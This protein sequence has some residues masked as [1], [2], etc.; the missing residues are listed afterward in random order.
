[1]STLVVSA[2]LAKLG[3]AFLNFVVSAALTLHNERV[4]GVKVP[5]R[6][7]AS[8]FASS[9]LAQRCRCP[10]R[11]LEKSEVVEAL[12]G[13]AW[14]NGWLTAEECVRRLL[15]ELRGGAS[16][17]EGL[18]SLVDSLIISFEKVEIVD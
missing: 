4:E 8:V 2:R 9:L 15:R 18:R 10:S 12:F 14:L 5:G 3:D 11:K 6:V 1:M 7:L 16:L 17:E 13:Y